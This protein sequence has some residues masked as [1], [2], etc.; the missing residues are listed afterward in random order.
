M[1]FDKDAFKKALNPKTILGSGGLSTIK[2]A[3]PGN[4]FRTGKTQAK[5]QQV[6]QTLLIE[7][8]RQS[9]EIRLAESTDEIAR[10]KALAKSTKSGRRSLI[11]TSEAGGG[12]LTLGGG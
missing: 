7:K 3:D 6:K 4:I 2:N 10:R 12:A 5:K 9:E 1:S 11:K 8:Q